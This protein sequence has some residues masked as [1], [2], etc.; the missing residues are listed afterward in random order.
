[1]PEQCSVSS[2]IN[3]A[4]LVSEQ[5]LRLEAEY[6]HRCLFGRGASPELVGNYLAAHG[7]MAELHDAPSEQLNTMRTIIARRLDAV[8][9]EPWLRKGKIRHLLSR[10]LLLIS[11]LAECDANHPEYVSYSAGFVRG[12]FK[13]LFAGLHAGFGLVI[14]RY[15]KARY[16]LL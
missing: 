4:A 13:L 9:V 10:K 6:L 11:Y 14:G 5:Q 7:A 8:L 12:W 1:M 15:L 3:H 2:F 16:G